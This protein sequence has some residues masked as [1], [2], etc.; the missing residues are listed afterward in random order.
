MSEDENTN[1]GYLLTP[2]DIDSG[3]LD[4]ISLQECFVLGVEWHTVWQALHSGR[5]FIQ[6]VHEANRE[7]IHRLCFRL[8]RI[9]EIHDEGDG[10]LSF[11]VGTGKTP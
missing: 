9:V 5:E 1:T 7:R 2:F 10:I 6:T 8:G 3:E 11:H 4:G